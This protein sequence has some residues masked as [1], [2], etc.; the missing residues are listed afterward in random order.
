MIRD[1]NGCVTALSDI[2]FNTLDKPRDLDFSI[3]SLNCINS[4]ASVELTVTGGS[5]PYTYEIIAPAGSVH[6]NGTNSTFTNLGLGSYTFRVTDGEGCFYDESYAITDISSI[7][8]R[9]EQTKVVGCQGEADG[10]GRFLVD[11]FGSTYSYSIDGGSTITGQSNG[12]LPISGLAAGSYVITVT[13]EQTH[14]TDTATLII[15]EPLMP[16]AQ[17]GLDV[18][19]MSCQNANRGAVRIHVEGG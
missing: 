14:C 8:V 10:A 18:T 12:T 3:S 6:D 11:G 19:D 17:T 9:A 13:D 16:F 5:G 7:G 4:T 15:E 1:A 2:V